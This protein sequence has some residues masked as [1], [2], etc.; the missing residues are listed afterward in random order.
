[1]MYLPESFPDPIAA[2][3]RDWEAVVARSLPDGRWLMVVPGVCNGRLLVDRD[4]DDQMWEE[5]YAYPTVSTALLALISWDPAT[6]P[7]PDGWVRHIP[8]YRRRPDGDP[9]NEY[10]AP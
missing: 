7:D 4:L 3:L 1:M 2:T 5:E 10:I 8:S 9:A 6:A